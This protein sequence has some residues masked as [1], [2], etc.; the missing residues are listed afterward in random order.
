MVILL[1]GVSGAGKTTTG[2][3]LAAELGWTFIDA[4][5]VHPPANIA[6]MTAGTPL[7]AAD[8]LPWIEAV[9]TLLRTHVQQGENVVL[10]CSALQAADRARLVDVNTRVVTVYLEAGHATIAARLAR[11]QG[12]FMNPDLLGSQYDALEPPLDA[13]V[14]DAARPPD[15]L[16]AAIRSGAG[17]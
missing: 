11:R 12:H 13:L 17:V 15:E 10:A 1:M 7:S 4:D 6:K 2:I 9:R 14:L 16:V 5:E 8:R 3:R